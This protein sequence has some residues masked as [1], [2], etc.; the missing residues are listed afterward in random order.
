MTDPEILLTSL[1]ESVLTITLNRPKVNAFDFKLIAAL[2][3]AFRQAERN[4]QARCVLLTGAGDNFS[5]GQDVNVFHHA[6]EISYREHLSRTYNPLIL[7]IRRLEK[8]V[9]AAVNGAVSGAALGIALA[10][11]LR[12]ASDRARFVVGF[13]GIGLA[14]DSAVSLL[15]PALIGLGRA[16]EFTFSNLPISADQALAWGLVNR[17][18]PAEQLNQQATMI[19]RLLAQGPV[20]AM[21][22]AKRSFNKAVL[23]N[24]EQVLD[25]E[26]YLQDIA[27]KNQE[28]KEGVQAFIEK[29]PAKFT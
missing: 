18:V 9:L 15:L 8:P 21:G 7:Q 24:L 22:L 4:D 6:E 25:Y 23:G 26:G 10:C 19:A 29:R 2:Q 1:E 13:A 5:A 14:P 20:H 16:A 3:A 12:I 17:L 27:S 11:D 28:H